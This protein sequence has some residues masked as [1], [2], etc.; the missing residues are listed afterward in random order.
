MQDPITD[1]Q[2]SQDP[3]HIRIMK[4]A[5]GSD[6]LPFLRSY[7]RV[8][9]VH[10]MNWPDVHYHTSEDKPNF[11]DPTQ[12]KRTAM[13]TMCVSLVMANAAPDDALLLTGLTAGG[14]VER[15]GQDLKDASGLL[16]AAPADQIAAAYKEGLVL[17]RQAY[18]R[19][20]AAIRSNALLMNN[21]AKALASLK[22][23]EKSVLASEPA[24]VA[25]F[26]SIYRAVAAQRG[27]TPPV[28]TPTLTAAETAASKLYPIHK[29]ANPY[30]DFA[31]TGVPAGQPSMHPGRREYALYDEEAINFADGS[32]SV[33]DIRDAISAELGPVKVE[34]VETFFRDLE[35]TGKW[36][37]GT[38]PS[39]KP[40]T[41]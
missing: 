35:R 10:F 16:R 19:E 27:Q 22:D 29:S 13:V 31:V 36:S 11:L 40:S 18:K 24:D 32:R 25:K 28:L 2:G 15:I 20:A 34:V 33:L 12:L 38:A 7:P 6:H 9:G 26:Q 14:A 30:D 3:Y 8:A 37:L 17:L 4:H 5:G 39:Q 1:P 23:I 21:D 41:P